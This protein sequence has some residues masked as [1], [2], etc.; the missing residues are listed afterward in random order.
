M[1]STFYTFPV[2]YRYG[3][4]SFSVNA[5]NVRTGAPA[6]SDN[7][8]NTSSD[9]DRFI[10]ECFGDNR[11]TN[12]RITHIRIVGEDMDNYSVSVPSGQGTG[13]GLSNQTI[14]S[15]NVVNGIQYDLRAVG[16]LSAREVQ[17]DVT[18]TN[19]KIYEV[20][21]IEEI[22]SISNRFQA[23]NPQRIDRDATIDRNILGHVLRTPGIQ[24]KWKWTLDLQAYFDND[25][26]PSADDVMRAF[27]ENPNFTI[28]MDPTRWP[29]RVFAGTLSAGIDIAYVGRLYSQRQLDFSVIES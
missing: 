19:H 7:N 10:I 20:M 2:N 16:P 25:T 1:N 17:I 27:E 29:D 24:N 18:G 28:A 12:S 3:R 11:T 15:G 8:P 14:P 21:L 22:T 6:I 23:I 9:E 26:T 5:S 13:T 4:Q